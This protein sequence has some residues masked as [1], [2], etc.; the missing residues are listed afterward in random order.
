MQL[1][2]TPQF[3]GW[4]KELGDMRAKQKIF[5]RIDRL[6]CGN[7]GDVTPVGGGVSEMRINYGPGYRVYFR[8]RGEAAT[9]LWGGIKDTQAADIAKAKALDQEWED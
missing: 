1:R 9:L 8:Q 6:E 3:A 7:A 4:L 2:R 5:V